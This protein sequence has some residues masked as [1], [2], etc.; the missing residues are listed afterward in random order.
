MIRNFKNSDIEKIMDIWLK[1]SIKGHEFISKEYWE[2]NYNTVKKVYIPMAE[3][4]V[5][6]D[7]GIIRGFISVI[8]NEF[9]GALFVDINYQ[10]KGIGKSLINYAMDKYKNLN[11]AVYK[12]NE[13]AVKFYLS[14]GFEIMKEQENEDSG[15]FEYIMNKNN[16]K[17]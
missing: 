2:N 7:K 3:T 10:N 5:Y 11:L 15:H 13:K 8:N 9:I 12:E 4:F 6:E 1:S 16:G 14:R 17:V